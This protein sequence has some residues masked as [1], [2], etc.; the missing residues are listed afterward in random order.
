MHG[1]ELSLVAWTLIIK[2][3]KQEET[4]CSKP[5]S[6]KLL[7]GNEVWC[8]PMCLG[9][10]APKQVIPILQ[11]C[12]RPWRGALSNVNHVEMVMCY[13]WN[14][15]TWARLRMHSCG[16]LRLGLMFQMNSYVVW[17]KWVLLGC[18]IVLLLGD[19]AMSTSCIL[20]LYEVEK[21]VSMFLQCDWVVVCALTTS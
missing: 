2:K 6:K 4:A 13:S 18:S 7:K 17:S 8:N 21:E 12:R 1:L 15:Y 10:G 3:V 11:G 16:N 19:Q 14:H 5:N 20:Y 9:P